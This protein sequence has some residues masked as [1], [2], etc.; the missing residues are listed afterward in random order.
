[1]IDVELYRW[2]INTAEHAIALNLL[3]NN[4]SLFF[5][6]EG[7]VVHRHDDPAGEIPFVFLSAPRPVS[8]V[9]NKGAS[10]TVERIYIWSPSLAAENRLSQFGI[11][12]PPVPSAYITAP[13]SPFLLPSSLVSFHF[14]PPAFHYLPPSTTSLLP[15]PPSFHFLSSTSSA[16]RLPTGMTLFIAHHNHKSKISKKGPE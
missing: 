12:F 13:L 4:N 3:N 16:L 15:L 11:P 7:M 14:L 5:F 1:M 6:S 10:V 8:I 2:C 9:L